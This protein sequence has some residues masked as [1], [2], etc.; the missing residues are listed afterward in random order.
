M[1]STNANAIVRGYFECV[2][3][4]RS[5]GIDRARRCCCVWS[6]SRVA[7]SRRPCAALRLGPGRSRAT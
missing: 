1:A 6:T 4:K 2:S 5:D 7:R 3:W